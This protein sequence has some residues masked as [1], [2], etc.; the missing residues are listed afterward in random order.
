MDPV[1]TWEPASAVRASPLRAPP[2]EDLP[3]RPASSRRRAV[4]FCCRPGPRTPRSPASRASRRTVR[5]RAEPVSYP[6]SCRL[7]FRLTLILERRKLLA[8]LGL[9]DI[10]RQIELDVHPRLAAVFLYTRVE[11]DVVHRHDLREGGQP[12]DELQTVL[13]AACEGELDLELVIRL[14]L[15]FLSVLLG[16]LLVRFFALGFRLGIRAPIA[17]G[18]R[19]HFDTR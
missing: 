6:V 19:L 10:R 13:I 14:G 11:G 18:R 17:P 8:G 15:L 3:R 1:E 2:G 5:R 12:L 7:S 9:Q 4:E 16:L